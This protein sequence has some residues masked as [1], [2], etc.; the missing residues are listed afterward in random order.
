MKKYLLFTTCL[1][2]LVFWPIQAQEITHSG[3]AA[4]SRPNTPERF[5][6]I[7]ETNYLNDLAL[8]GFNLDTQGLLVESLD[9][10]Q[11]FA[12]LNSNAG[13]N[14]ASVIKVATSFTAFFK[15]GPEYHFETAFYADGDI[16]RK[17]RTLNGDLILLSTGDPV[18][19]ATDITRLAHQVLSAGIA[20]VSGSLI[21]TGPLTYNAFETTDF[22][23]KRIEALLRKMG[24]RVGGPSKKG[25]VRGTKIASHLSS[26]LRD[27]VFFQNAHS[28]N[29]TAE[30]LGEAVGGPKAV[31]KFL[32][33]EVGLLPSEITLTHTSGLD[34]N[35]IT[36]HGTILILRHLVGWLNFHNMLPEDV[37][38]V[39]GVD[40]GTLRGRLVAADGSVV[41]KTGTLPG[42]DGGVSTLAGIM[43][44]RDRGPVLFAIFNTR[45][46]VNTYRRLQD[47][48]LKDLIAECGGSQLA[49]VS[50]RK[51]NN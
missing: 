27:I 14:P 1:M 8:R 23:T 46:S 24:I 47:N 32:I 42:T 5:T 30:R 20:R 13:F 6:T 31:E 15:L 44:T 33:Q 12:N 29:Q 40:P 19:T 35:R 26:S 3:P 48:L 45:G 7:A 10:S 38:P 36:P 43:Y 51:S 2:L 9:G 41:A 39:A 49:S 22:A 4:E 28:V 17:T 21:V 34:Y 25:A 37:M 50:T 18:L 16:N 11:V